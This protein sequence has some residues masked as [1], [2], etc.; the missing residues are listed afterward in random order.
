MAVVN[1]ADVIV[2]GAGCAGL[3]AAV[4]AARAGRRVIVLEA[5]SRLGGRATAFSDRETGELVD[6]GQHVLLGCYTATFDFLREIGASD[7]V[8]LQ[9]QLQISIVDAQGRRS[10]F[11]CADLPT[12]FHLLAGILDWDALSWTDRLAALKMATPLKLARRAMQ[13][14]SRTIAASP[15]ETVE[16]WLIRNGQT[17]RLRELL[18]EPLALAALNQSASEAAAPVFARV[19]AE[20]FGSD[21]RSAAIALPIVP[22]NRMYAEPARRYLEGHGGQVIT[23]AAVKLRIEGDGRLTAAGPDQSWTAPQVV[24]AVPWFA[25]PDLFELPPPALA[26]TFARARATAASPIVTVNLWFDREVMDVPFLGLPGRV[27]QWAFDKRAVWGEDDHG[28]SQ[29]SLVSSGASSIL[30]LSNPELVRIAHEEMMTAL[31]AAR[32]A[33]LTRASVIREPN[34]GF[35]VAPGQPARPS[36]VT[37]VRGFYLAGDWIDTGLPATIESAVRSGH[38]AADAILGG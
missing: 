1:S 19:L 17:P 24:S 7:H 9:R 2:V 23:G 34:A 11:Q 26:E 37:G 21:A 4:R 18:W 5:R 13:P 3:S 35:S 31:P 30:A 8:R 22:L 36:T 38:M 15:G 10:R 28:A 12:P 16:N 27:M 32:S 29:L 20:A 6:N 33:K 25:L 14:G